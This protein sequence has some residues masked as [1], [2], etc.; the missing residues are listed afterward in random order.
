VKV[1][2]TGPSPDPDVAIPLSVAAPDV[3]GV[4]ELAKAGYAHRGTFLAT[5]CQRAPG[6]PAPC[7]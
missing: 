5:A 7:R 3:V 6:L 1:R 4:D 2:A